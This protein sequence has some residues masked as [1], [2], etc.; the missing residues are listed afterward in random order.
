MEI[1]KKVRQARRTGLNKKLSKR[2]GSIS[3]DN[4]YIGKK[5]Y[6]LLEEEHRNNKKIIK[7]ITRIISKIKDILE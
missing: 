6:V 5:V 1:L 3:L 7:N 2:M 4:K